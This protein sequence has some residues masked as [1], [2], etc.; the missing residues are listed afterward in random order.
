MEHPPTLDLDG[1]YSY[2]ENST[3]YYDFSENPKTTAK[4][5]V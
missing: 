2:Y 3:S 4:I 5:I 1:N